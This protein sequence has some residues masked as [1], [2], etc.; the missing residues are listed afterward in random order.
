L[1]N[2]EVKP[3]DDSEAL[4]E[5]IEKLHVENTRLNAQAQV[6]GD[7]AG[8]HDT[9]LSDLTAENADLKSKLDAANAANADLTKKLAASEKAAALAVKA[10]AP[11]PPAESPA[12]TV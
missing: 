11:A 6:L 10:A 7:E 8:K 9:T 5:Q 1:N 12:A 2:E 3:A 4:M